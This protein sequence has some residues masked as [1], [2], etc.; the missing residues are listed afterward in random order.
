[1]IVKL[2][3]STGNVLG[4]LLQTS[5]RRFIT[6][7]ADAELAAAVKER[8]RQLYGEVRFELPPLSP[9]GTP[10]R[11]TEVRRMR[12]RALTA[13]ALLVT[14]VFLMERIV[15]HRLESYEYLPTLF[16]ALA[17]D[18][19][20][21]LDVALGGVL[22]LHLVFVS[23]LLVHLYELFDFAPNSPLA[24][25]VAVERRLRHERFTAADARHCAEL[26]RELRA[27]QPI[28]ASLL[29]PLALLEL[30]IQLRA[31][32]DEDALAAPRHPLRRIDAIADFLRVT[33]PHTATL[34][35]LLRDRAHLARLVAELVL[36]NEAF[37]ID[38]CRIGLDAYY[39][40][41]VRFQLERL[42]NSRAAAH[43]GAR[44]TFAGL[45]QH[46]VLHNI[47]H[48]CA[49]FGRFDAVRDLDNVFH[50][51]LGELVLARDLAESRA[52]RNYLAQ[53]RVL[54]LDD[55]DDNSNSV[56]RVS[57]VM[58]LATQQ[59]A[60]SSSSSGSLLLHAAAPLEAVA[61]ASQNM[62]LLLLLK[63]PR[64]SID[65]IARLFAQQRDVDDFERDTNAKLQLDLDEFLIAESNARTNTAAA[66]TTTTS[67]Q[68]LIPA[69]AAADADFHLE[70]LAFLRQAAADDARLA[71]MRG[72]L[73][74]QFHG[75]EQAL[76]F[77][78]E[79]LRLLDR[80]SGDHAVVLAYRRRAA[81]TLARWDDDVA[82]VDAAAA[83][84]A[85]RSLLSLARV[86]A[87]ALR[88]TTADDLSDALTLTWASAELGGLCAPCMRR[89]R[90]G[91]GTQLAA[92]PGAGNAI[93]WRW[94]YALQREWTNERSQ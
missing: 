40:I 88:H 9:E 32:A 30:R 81:R 39:D 8:R 44:G 3:K 46:N 70:A 50:P 48:A 89:Q 6:Q 17:S 82:L 79:A 60:S 65:R 13:L 94:L 63:S 62:A 49:T 27:R 90:L 91:G 26:V 72:K 45:V 53:S 73:W 29:V 87:G 20:V 11:R 85:E 57:T 35:F 25:F 54:R 31:F 51:T 64:E 12:R 61:L 52:L 36:A 56:E 92:L 86:S 93:D 18:D 84:E 2:F 74:H 21:E 14:A 83:E 10:A 16:E 28:A 37:A 34:P 43:Y 19:A 1:M 47:A 5:T 42:A 80:A 71:F 4:R 69:A 41:L 7:R 58:L 67:T 33:T 15:E 68:H 38:R 22:P 76:V 55:D 75:T 66:A 78:D 77:Y 23:S 24:V 59:L